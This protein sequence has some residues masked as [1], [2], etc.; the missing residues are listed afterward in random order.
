MTPDPRDL[1]KIW[2]L[3]HGQTDWNAIRRIQGQLNSDLTERGIQDAETQ[4]RLIQPILATNPQ[5]YVSPLRRA[6]QTAQIALAGHTYSNDTRLAEAHAGDWQGRLRKDVL[7][8]HPDLS[9][10]DISPLELYLKAPGGEGLDQF[11]AR[12]LSFLSDLTAPSV[13]VGHGLWGQVMRG[14]VRGLTWE[15]TT[16]LTN[17]QACIYVMENRTET[18]LRE[19]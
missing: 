15:E 18:V 12:I 8:D 5:C 2:F 11:R 3:R 14:F 13:I 4:A 7:Q 9:A 17:E 6:Q 10:P 19:L 16:R 1:P